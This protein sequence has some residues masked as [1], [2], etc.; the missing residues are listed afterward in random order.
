[1]IDNSVLKRL[2]IQ[3]G[4]QVNEDHSIEQNVWLEQ[5]ETFSQAVIEE[6]KSSLVP[7]GYVSKDTAKYF[8]NTSYEF[9]GVFRYGFHEDS[10]IP[11]Y[12]LPKG[13]TK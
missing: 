3:C 5:L 11:I 8:G 12:A 9:T 6:Y 7:V 10:K 2:A 4:L 13:E 1:M